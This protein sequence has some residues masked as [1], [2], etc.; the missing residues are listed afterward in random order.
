MRTS[1]YHLASLE[2]MMA[3]QKLTHATPLSQNLRYRVDLELLLTD[4]FFMY[5]AHMPTGQI[6]PKILHEVWFAHRSE[7]DLETQLQQAA[8]TNQVGELLQSLRPPHADHIVLPHADH[9]V[10]QKALMSY[11]DMAARGGWPVIPDGPTLQR[12]DRGPR[13]V[14]LYT[15]LLLSGDL[16]HASDPTGDIF[17]AGLERA[18]QQFQERHGLDADGIIGSS[19]LIALNVPAAA[20]ARQIEL[21]MERWRWLPHELEERFILVNL[22]NFALDVVEHGR[23]TLAMHVVV[24]TPDALFQC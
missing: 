11:R 14:T 4:A 9:I 5:G 8:E 16:D 15:R 10:L 6:D 24:G 20:R 22:A 13:V 2:R 17:D 23:S 7:M 18:L 19:T 3:E 12:G 1:S 21:N